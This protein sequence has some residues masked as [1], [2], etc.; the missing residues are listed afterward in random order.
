M[1]FRH[2][3]TLRPKMFFG[4][5]VYIAC[6]SSKWP[7]VNCVTCVSFKHSN[8]K[9][10]TKTLKNK[11]M[12]LIPLSMLA[13]HQSVFLHVSNFQGYIIGMK[14][15]LYFAITSATSWSI[16]NMT[17]TINDHSIFQVPKAHW[18]KK[19]TE[20]LDPT[21]SELVGIVILI[22]SSP[23]LLFMSHHFQAGIGKRKQQ[24]RVEITKPLTWSFT[25]TTNKVRQSKTK[26]PI[27][28]LTSQK[29]QTTNEGEITESF[30]QHSLFG[31][32]IA[33]M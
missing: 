19:I 7:K 1:F 16:K 22:S 32:I 20:T 8:T 11:I 30:P 24:T 6:S 28:S 15:H 33:I 2:S 25:N 17:G 4:R 13:R 18:K 26:L 27:F 5:M 3:K 14:F 31:L 21:S 10:S 12:W 23:L 29:S 9:K